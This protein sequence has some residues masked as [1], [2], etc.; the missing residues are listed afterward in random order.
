MA[1]ELTAH[2][3][4]GDQVGEPP[5][6]R[7]LELAA[8]LAQLGLDVGHTEELVDL[9][10]GG[11][12]VGRAGRVVRDSVLA[13]MEPA[14]HGVGSQGL[15]V[16]LRPGEVLE[17]VSEVLG[18]DDAEVDHAQRVCRVSVN[19]NGPGIEPA[20]RDRVFRP[21]FTTKAAGTGLGLALVLKIIVTHN[22]RVI[23]GTAPRGG[24]SLQVTLP[25]SDD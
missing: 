2:V 17:Q 13:H 19:D 4:D 14:A 6:A 18:R 21:F 5:L 25:L 22:G 10:L 7:G 24:A 3:L 8:V 9:L 16:L 20:A 1:V 12:R 23:V 11:A 15:I